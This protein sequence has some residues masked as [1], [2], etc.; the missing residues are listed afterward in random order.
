MKTTL[1]TLAIAGLALP[2][3]Y[4]CASDGN[5]GPQAAAGTG[6]TTN[7]PAS[8]GSTTA[9]TTTGTSGGTTAGAQTGTSA[10]TSSGGS[11]GGLGSIPSLVNVNLQNVLNDL[12][13]RLKVDRANIPV[14]AQIPIQ[15]A[16]NVCGVSIN[17]LSVSTGGQAQCEA[18]TAPAEL[19][20]VVQQQ[21][22]AGGSVGGGAQGG[23][24]AATG[25]STPASGTATGGSTSGST[26]STSG[27][28]TTTTP[29]TTTPPN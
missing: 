9:G 5:T 22:A 14:N 26:T 7:A 18:K 19:A 27:G 11:S 25:S 20:Q 6:T 23:S 13:V 8:G 2:F 15:L 12:S 16:A 29:S 24:T 4:A 1:K 28:T 21:M 3:A 10:N 17:V